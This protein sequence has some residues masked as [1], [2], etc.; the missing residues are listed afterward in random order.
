MLFVV[1][2]L[3]KDRCGGS[4]NLWDRGEF[5]IFDLSNDAYKETLG[6]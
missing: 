4:Q 2:F 6:D 3:Q 5:S 1:S